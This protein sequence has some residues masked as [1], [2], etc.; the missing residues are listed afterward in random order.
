MFTK[1]KVVLVATLLLGVASGARAAGDSDRETGGYQ[2]QTWQD[3]EQAR[4]NM[5]NLIQRQYGGQAFGYVASPKH[6]G[7][8][9]R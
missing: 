3:V 1:I 7:Q 6:D 9:S 2:V 5:Q 4:Q 8:R